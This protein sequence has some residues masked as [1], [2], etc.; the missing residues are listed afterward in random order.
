MAQPLP[1]TTR[2][3]IYIYT[4]PGTIF[5]ELIFHDAVGLP[6]EPRMLSLPIAKRLL[7]DFQR[8]VQTACPRNG[9]GPF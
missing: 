6:S 7:K 5:V 1:K 8:G 9:N 4:E 2:P 3:C